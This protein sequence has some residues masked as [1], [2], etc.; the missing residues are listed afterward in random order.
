M[1]TTVQ[2][3]PESTERQIL[4]SN[5]PI[6]FA[7]IKCTHKLAISNIVAP[8]LARL[9]GLSWCYLTEATVCG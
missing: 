5:Q 4:H 8:G 3:G 2:A 7:R 6:K 9:V 1:I